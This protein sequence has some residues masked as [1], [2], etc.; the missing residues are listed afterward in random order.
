[1]CWIILGKNV[2][3]TQSKKKKTNGSFSA[4]VLIG[5]S[6]IFRFDGHYKRRTTTQRFYP[7]SRRYDYSIV[8]T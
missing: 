2:F 6:K 5:L 4:I 7:I 8:Y 1:M 3:P